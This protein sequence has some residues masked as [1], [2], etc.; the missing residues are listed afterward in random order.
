MGLGSNLLNRVSYIYIY[1]LSSA[2]ISSA[3]N[4]ELERLVWKNMA[5]ILFN[6]I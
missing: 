3:K 2:Q 6:I 4:V 1:I 5:D